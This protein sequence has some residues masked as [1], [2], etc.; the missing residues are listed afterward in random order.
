MRIVILAV[1]LVLSGCQ[2]TDPLRFPNSTPET[3]SVSEPRFEK[4]EL[5]EAEALEIGKRFAE[6]KS[7][8]LKRIPKHANYYGAEQEWQVFFGIV[9]V[10]GPY[11]VYVNDRTKAARFVRG[12]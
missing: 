12:E 7:W 10:G 2:N 1:T 11:I 5:T 9:G 4:P 6:E 3:T 8:Q